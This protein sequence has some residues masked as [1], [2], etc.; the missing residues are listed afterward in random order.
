M[1]LRHGRGPRRSHLA[2]ARPRRGTGADHFRPHFARRRRHRPRRSIDHHVRAGSR[3]AAVWLHDKNGDHQISSEGNSAAPSFSSDGGS[4]YFLAND[5]QSRGDELRV[6]NLASGIVQS[7]LPG[8]DMDSYSIASDGKQVAFAMS[9]GGH[10]SIW[11][12]PTDRRSS[13]V[14]LSSTANDDFPHFLPDGDIVFRSSEAGV[15]FFFRMK[16]DGT[17]RRK[18]I[19]EH[20]LDPVSVSSDGRWLVA[21]VPGPDQDHGVLTKAFAIDGQQRGHTL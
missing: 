21:A 13:P 15:N 16:A 11:I 2:A 10:S 12:A 8:Y 3:D 4:L 20:I 5:G 17:W 6:Q 19:P 1:G 14:K 7:V 9:K 18:A